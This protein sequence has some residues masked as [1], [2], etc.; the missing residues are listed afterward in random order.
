LIKSEIEAGTTTIKQVPF[1]LFNVLFK[2]QQEKKE[3]RAWDIASKPQDHSILIRLM[4]RIMFSEN[5]AVGQVFITHR[6]IVLA[7]DVNVMIEQ[8]IK[9][10]MEEIEKLKV[11]GAPL[12]DPASFTKTRFT[13]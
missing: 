2:W 6:D 13:Q 10:A 9:K 5:V 1:D 8:R 11:E 12:I 4:E 7:A 3:D